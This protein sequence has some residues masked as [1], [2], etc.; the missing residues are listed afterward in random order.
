M[1]TAYMVRVVLL[2]PSNRRAIL[3]T[4]LSHGD[5]DPADTAN[6]LLSG[7]NNTTG[8]PP[9]TH[10]L[11]NGA[12]T[13]HQFKRFVL[14]VCEQLSVSLPAD[15]D[16]RTP[17]Q[18]LDFLNSRRAMIL[19]QTGVRFFCLR[20]DQEWPDFDALLLQQGFKRIEIVAG[21]NG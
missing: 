2:A 17:D 11:Y 20:N 19:S 7:Y 18:K 14:W 12:H 10:W 21:V 5:F 15:F 8:L 6:E 9:F 4:L 3:R 1:A 16:D 13:V